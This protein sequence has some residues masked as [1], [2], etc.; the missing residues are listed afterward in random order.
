MITHLW[1]LTLVAVLE[2]PPSTDWAKG[3]VAFFVVAAA[4]ITGSVTTYKVIKNIRANARAAKTNE[5]AAIKKRIEDAVAAETA[6]HVAAKVEAEHQ[7]QL[8]NK[9]T[10]HWESLANVFKAEKEHLQETSEADK[11]KFEIDII[12]IRDER[13][14]LTNQLLAERAKV[15]QVVD[16]NLGLQ[17]QITENSKHL[18]AASLQIEEL[19]KKVT[20]ID[21]VQS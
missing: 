16:L 4:V 13:E 20:R 6:L 7:L 19:Q 15:E 21:G 12:R 8:A 17:G 10:E 14:V 18:K 9:L 5:E 2:E 11:K 1:L 3:I